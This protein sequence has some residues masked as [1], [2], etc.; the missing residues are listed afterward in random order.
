M[1]PLDRREGRQPGLET[2]T[3]KGPAG[4][5]IGLVERRLEDVG[6][7]ETTRHRGDGAAERQRVGVA[8]D[9]TGATN[10][11]EWRP[12]SDRHVADA[13]SS[14]ATIIDTLEDAHGVSGQKSD[15][16]RQKITG[17]LRRLQRNGAGAAP[18]RAIQVTVDS[19]A[20]RVATLCS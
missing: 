6:H 17:G 19:V 10:Q 18:W 4:S 14:H 12:V 7:A 16:R 15:G 3:A 13:H 2:R 1:R 11:D 9:D 20:G 5:A 8:L